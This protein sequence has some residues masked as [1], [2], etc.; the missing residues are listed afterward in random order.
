MVHRVLLQ[1]HPPT[2]FFFLCGFV[3]VVVLC[4]QALFLNSSPIGNT[5]VHTGADFDQVFI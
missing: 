1:L 4:Y 5:N 3:I 2:P